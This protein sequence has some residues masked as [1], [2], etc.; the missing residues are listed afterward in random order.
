MKTRLFRKKTNRALANNEIE[1]GRTFFC[2]EL[3]AKGFKLAG[4]LKN[5]EISSAQFYPSSFG[6]DGQDFLKEN[7]HESATIHR[8]REIILENT[9]NEDDESS[10]GDEEEND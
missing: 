9:N 10:D 8:E 3:I 7:L 6:E 1:E 5:N 4:V 2:S